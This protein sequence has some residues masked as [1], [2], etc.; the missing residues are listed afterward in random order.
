LTENKLFFHDNSR[1]YKHTVRS[2]ATIKGGAV[3]SLSTTGGL[4][5]FVNSKEVAD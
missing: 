2:L 4:F 1:D 3:S 5:T